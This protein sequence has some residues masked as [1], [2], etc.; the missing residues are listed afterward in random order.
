MESQHSIGCI[1]VPLSVMDPKIWTEKRP[2][3]RWWAALKMKERVN[4][5][6]PKEPPAQSEGQGRSRGHQGAQDDRPDRAD[7]RRAPHAGRGMEEAGARRLARY[8]Q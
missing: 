7:V 1:N 2:F 3:L 8:L 6:N 4:A 5:T